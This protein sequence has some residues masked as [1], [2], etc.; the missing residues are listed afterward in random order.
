VS[1]IMT[2]SAKDEDEW[3]AEL[4]PEQYR[5][6]RLRG[7]ERPF[8][9]NLLHNEE[10]GTYSCAGCG[11]DL[12]R[13]EA[14]F[15][16]GSGWPSFMAPISEDVI[17]ERPDRSHGMARTEIVCAR[18]GGH[19]GHVFDDGPAPSGLRYCVNSASLDF[20]GI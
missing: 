17:E 4:T 16:S 3:K 1:F 15:D 6:L 8:T 9:G 18:C 20:K 2:D 14:K 7:T 11:A 10:K 12:F 5:V 19:L 13:S